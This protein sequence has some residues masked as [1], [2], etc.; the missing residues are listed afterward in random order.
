MVQWYT[1]G[2]RQA[3]ASVACHWPAVQCKMSHLRRFPVNCHCFSD[4]GLSIETGPKEVPYKSPCWLGSN[5]KFFTEVEC[6]VPPH[7]CSLVSH[8]ECEKLT[9]KTNQYHIFSQTQIMPLVLFC[10]HIKWLAATLPQFLV[11]SFQSSICGQSRCA[12]FVIQISPWFSRYYIHKH[13]Q[14][15]AC[16]GDCFTVWRY[17]WSSRYLYIYIYLIGE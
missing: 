15:S 17:G 5:Y 10:I 1:L 13:H 8:S 12:F 2:H 16:S 7:F 14:T 9:V 11:Q 4:L 3:S 6:K